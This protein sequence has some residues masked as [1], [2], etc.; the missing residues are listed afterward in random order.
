MAGDDDR[1]WVVPH[2][3]ANRP[4]GSW[5][6]GIRGQLGIGSHL[7]SWDGPGGGPAG[8]L[9]GRS[10]GG[11]YVIEFNRFSGKGFQQSIREAREELFIVPGEQVDALSSGSL[12]FQQ[13]KPAGGQPTIGR[14][15]EGKA[16]KAGFE[17]AVPRIL[18]GNLNRN[19]QDMLS[20]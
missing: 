9:E 15:E 6:S 13:F 1:E 4:G 2:G 14:L 7:P 12:G 18:H 3:L 20:P 10:P 8:L 5:R 11:G 19:S 16:T 17:D